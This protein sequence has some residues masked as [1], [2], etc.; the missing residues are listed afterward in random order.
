MRPHAG[1]LL[2]GLCICAAQAERDDSFYWATTV[3]TETVWTICAAQETATVFEQGPFSTS[4]V[5]ANAVLTGITVQPASSPTSCYSLPTPASSLDVIAFAAR[6]AST[7]SNATAS[8]PLFFYLGDNA[9][10]PE[11]VGTLLNGTQCLL[12]ISP[13]AS[14]AGRVALMLAGGES[15]VFDQTGMHHYNGG[16]DAVSSVTIANFSSQIMA[17]VDSPDLPTLSDI[18]QTGKMKRQ[19]PETNFTVVVQIDDAIN[20]QLLKPQVSFG[21]SPCT[22]LTQSEVGRWQTLIWTC[23]RPGANSSEKTCE[24]KFHNWFN[25][26]PVAPSPGAGSTNNG[27]DLFNHLPGFMSKLGHS[28]TSLFPGLS[29]ALLQAVGWLKTARRAVLNAAEFGGD[30]L[31]LVLHAMDEYT[32]VLSDPGLPTPHTIGVYVSPPVPTI[33][34]TMALWTSR[35]TKEPPRAVLPKVTGFPS[36]TE[37][38]FTPVSFQFTRL[39]ALFG[40]EPVVAGMNPTSEARAGGG[41]SDE[42]MA[43]TTTTVYVM[44][45]P[46]GTLSTMSLP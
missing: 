6:Q 9:T 4:I 45:T 29:P 39:T 28:I 13:N 16:C 31:C 33:S 26:D 19:L 43:A 27:T 22:L 44:A 18:P 14:A 24:A 11:Y 2:G 17:I 23:Q 42:P 46:D 10:S 8:N 32:L 40:L 1:F 25:P 3:I 7:S 41:D 34:D 15:L 20:G 36:V 38:S 21:P 5:L 12:D 37:T 30:E 35:I